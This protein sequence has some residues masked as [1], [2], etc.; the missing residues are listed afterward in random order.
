MQGHQDSW[1]KQ[2]TTDLFANA[3]IPKAV[4]ANAIP[5][6]ISMIMVLVYN[7]ADTF[8]IGQTGNPYMVAAVSVVTPVFLIFMAVGMLFGIGGTSLIS[9]KLGEGDTAAAKKISSFCCWTGL[10]VGIL[11]MF[12]L[13]FFSEQICRLIGTSEDTIGYAKQYLQII[14]VGVPFL[15][16]GNSFSTII[17]AE[18][19]A[20]LAMVGMILG[21]VINIVLDPIL[22]LG[23]GWNIA[24]AAIATVIG[25]IAAAVFYMACVSSKK[26]MLSINPKDYAFKNNIATGVLAIGIPASLN[27][28]LMSFSN[29]LV[30]NLMNSHSDMPLAGLGVAMKE[31]MKE[32]S[33]LLG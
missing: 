11:C 10:A 4:L 6:I 28:I 2:K 1:V 8:F 25:N 31:I 32:V 23:F 29:I 21:N 33:L 7:L 22:I 18:G 13:F 15:I 20:N 3:P 12:T 19:K 26:S 27:S 17:R 24:G 9:R 5:A 30:N 14:A 16:V